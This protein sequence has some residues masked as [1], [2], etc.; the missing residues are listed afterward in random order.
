MDMQSYSPFKFGR[1]GR[2]MVRIMSVLLSYIL[3]TQGAAQWTQL[4]KARAFARQLLCLNNRQVAF[5]LQL[6]QK[7]PG[8]G[9]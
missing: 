4:K 7:A 1:F 2:E 6:L 8:T 5:F 9:K 3:E